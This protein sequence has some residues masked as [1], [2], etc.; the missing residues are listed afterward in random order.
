MVILLMVILLMPYRKIVADYRD[1]P[2]KYINASTLCERRVMFVSKQVVKV[3]VS[4]HSY[5][6]QR[7]HRLVCAVRRRITRQG[8]FRSEY[9]L[10]FWQQN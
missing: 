3:N 7:V 4:N 6:Y 8:L 5:F 10:E 2:T 9:V 1:L